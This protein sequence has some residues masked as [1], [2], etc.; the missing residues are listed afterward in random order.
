MKKVENFCKA[1]ENLKE[2]YEHEE[3]YENVVLTGLV[4]YY[5]ICFEQAWKAM[6]EIL[7]DAGYPESSTG[8]P[9]QILKVAYKA[10]LIEDEQAWQ[11][12]LVSRNNVAHSYNESVALDIVRKTKDC[13]YDLLCKLKN[14]IEENWN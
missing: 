12:A 1:L 7:E 4:A 2:I 5:S 3:P 9:K 6:K 13:Y 11:Q 14:E 10:G 8:S